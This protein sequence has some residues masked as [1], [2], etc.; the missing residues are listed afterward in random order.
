VRRSQDG[1]LP[2]RGGNLRLDLRR[3]DLAD[4]NMIAAYT[5]HGTDLF[6][7]ADSATALLA[8][9]LGAHPPEGSIADVTTRSLAAYRLYEQGLRSFS[10]GDNRSAHPLFEAALAEDSTF[11]MAAYCRA[12]HETDEAL[13]RLARAAGLPKPPR[14]GSA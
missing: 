12:Q 4:G 14:T 10:G 1:D 6:S 2:S 3:I 7:L 9:E 5:V 8:R 11:A 13:P